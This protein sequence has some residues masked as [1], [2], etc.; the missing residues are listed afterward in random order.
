MLPST[1]AETLE[2]LVYRHLLMS[3][4]GQKYDT[5]Q[6][7]LISR[8]IDEVRTQERLTCFSSSR[9]DLAAVGPD[10]LNSWKIEVMSD[11][12]HRA[13]QQLATVTGMSAASERDRLRDSIWKVLSAAEQKDVWFGRQLAASQMVLSAAA[14][15]PR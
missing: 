3:Q 12:Y 7:Q 10:V 9:A 13:S 15:P 2:F 11:L 5:S 14:R 6:P 8:F 4:L 1:K